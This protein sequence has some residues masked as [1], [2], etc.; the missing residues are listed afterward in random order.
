[1]GS[2]APYL[3][4]TA[5]GYGHPAET[6]PATYTFNVWISVSVSQE[7][8]RQLEKKE[9]LEQEGGRVGG[10]GAGCIVEAGA[11][12]P[13]KPGLHLLFKLALELGADN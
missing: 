7:F 8:P 11:A 5:S 9:T 13:C 6:Q 3:M 10:A 12:D 4:G 2:P 1:M